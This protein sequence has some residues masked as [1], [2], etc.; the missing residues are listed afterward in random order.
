MDRE[1]KILFNAEC[2]VCN[3]EISHYA[4]YS[5]RN[6][7]PLRFEDLNQTDL[8]AWGMTADQAAQR[9]YVLKDGTLYDG[10]PAFL[11][12]W[13]DMPRYRWLGRIVSLPVIR[14]ICTALYDLVV[15]PVI[16]RWHK[17]R[18]ARFRA[19]AETR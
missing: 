17:R 10:I 7:L 8:D 16:Y 4:A 2:P 5:D 18:K 14:Q 12:L 11:V 1:T 9:L 19:A 6:A 13:A 15:A 3:Y